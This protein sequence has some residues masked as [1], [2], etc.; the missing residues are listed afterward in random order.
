MLEPRHLEA[1]IATPCTGGLSLQPDFAAVPLSPLTSS[2][3]AHFPPSTE[4]F[5]NRYLTH[6]M[7]PRCTPWEWVFPPSLAT[8]VV[9]VSASL[10][11]CSRRLEQGE[12]SSYDI[13]ASATPK[14]S[15]LHIYAVTSSPC[16]NH[17]CI[18]V[19]SLIL[20]SCLSLQL[21]L[22]PEILNLTL[23]GK[24]YPSLNHLNGT[25]KLT[26]TGGLNHAHYLTPIS[27]T[28]PLSKSSS[29]ATL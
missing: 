10:R 12:R 16:R 17:L 19:F 23:L 15:T 26:L 6:R 1:T 2:M 27:L 8:T 24:G 5:P 3:A 25:L 4:I 14:L 11:H 21:L 29:P 22:D 13:L 20:P 9:L 18:C 7:H 28:P